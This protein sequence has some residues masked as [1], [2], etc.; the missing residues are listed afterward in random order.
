MFDAFHLYRIYQKG[1]IKFN[2]L[3][4]K[5]IQRCMLLLN[6]FMYKRL[7]YLRSF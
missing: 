7:L 1:D 3:I 2:K 4:L 6:L 5:V